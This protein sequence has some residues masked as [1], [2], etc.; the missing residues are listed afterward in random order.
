M[1]FMDHVGHTA[2]LMMRI[3]TKRNQK[4]TKWS[5]IL[6]GSNSFETSLFLVQ[7]GILLAFLLRLNPT[8]IT[9][10][11]RAIDT[12]PPTQILNMIKDQTLSNLELHKYR[13]LLGLYA[14]ASAPN[15]CNDREEA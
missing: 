6:N 13:Y 7:T 1:T 4:S 12:K 2:A 5:K 9:S 10:A 8:F 15:S 3:F 11:L 14:A